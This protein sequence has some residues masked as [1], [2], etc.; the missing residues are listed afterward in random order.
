[1]LFVV[2]ME[3]SVFYSKQCME[4]GGCGVLEHEEQIILHDSMNIIPS[5]IYTFPKILDGYITP[6]IGSSGF[7][8]VRL[9]FSW[10]LIISYAADPFKIHV[11]I[12]LSNMTAPY[13]AVVSLF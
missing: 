10:R 12:R 8:N 2:F 11:M 9:N 4:S 5:P 7:R 13:L 3:G 6:P 1:M